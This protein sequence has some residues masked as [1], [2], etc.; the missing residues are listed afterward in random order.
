MKSKSNK[1]LT[2]ASVVSIVGI[3]IL[4]LAYSQIGSLNQKNNDLAIETSSLYTQAIRAESLKKIVSNAGDKGIS[5]DEYFI[6]AGEEVEFV[7][8]LETLASSVNLNYTTNSI[9]T[10]SNEKLDPLGKELLEISMVTEGSWQNTRR[11]ISLIEKMPMNIRINAMDL[12]TEIR[13]T[14]AAP[15]KSETISSTTPAAQSP[16]RTMWKTTI[17]MVVVKKK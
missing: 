7:K 16:S 6:A 3:I 5:L 14:V 10:Q 15:T 11:F 8:K 2:I 12:K 9:G 4:Y 13:T 1:I 17:S